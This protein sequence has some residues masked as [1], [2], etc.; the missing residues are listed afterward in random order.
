MLS[1]YYVATLAYSFWIKRIV[2]MDVLL[3]A[4]LY[5]ARVLA[6]AAATDVTPSFWLLAFSMFT[7]LS[8]ALVKRYTELLSRTAQGQTQADGRGYRAEDMESLMSL[9]TSSG[10]AAVLVLA[11]YI[12]SAN[13]HSLYRHP[14][15][16]WLLCPL[17]L[18]WI[19][20]VWLGARRGKLHDDPLVFALRDRVSR[21][22]LLIGAAILVAAS[23]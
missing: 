6:G 15:A 5:T 14:R 10:Y 3:L 12:N 19:S 22:V 20:R 23:Y 9:G 2:V 4:A 7:F 17:L 8:L 13:V 16:I 1:A 18:Y 21:Y 11:L